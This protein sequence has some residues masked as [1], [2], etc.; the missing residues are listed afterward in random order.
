MVATSSRK[1]WAAV[2][3]TNNELARLERM[4]PAPDVSLSQGNFPPTDP[5]AGYSWRR[6]ITDLEPL[7]GVRVRRVQLDLEWNLGTSRQLHR[8]SLYVVPN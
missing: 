6:E 3:Y 8:A 4:S 2:V 1:L 5:M 7:P